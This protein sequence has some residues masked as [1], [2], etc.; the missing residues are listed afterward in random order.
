[1]IEW[2]TVNAIWLGALGAIAAVIALFTQ[3]L[4]KKESRNSNVTAENGGVASGGDMKGVTV[5]TN[6]SRKKKQP[7]DI[8]A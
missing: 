5:T 6:S 2:L 7:G 3:F 1:M 8:D 4:N